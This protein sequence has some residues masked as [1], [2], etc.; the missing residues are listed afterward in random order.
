MAKQKPQRVPIHAEHIVWLDHSGG[1]EGWTELDDIKKFVDKEFFIHTVGFVVAENKERVVLVQ[2]LDHQM[3]A[4][5]HMTLLKTDIVKRQRI[6][7]VI[8]RID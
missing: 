7:K 1:S 5:H 8:E 2:N 6:S 4:S 3:L